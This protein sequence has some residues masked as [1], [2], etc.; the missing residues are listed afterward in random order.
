MT[1]QIAAL[2][3][4]VCGG[5]AAGD[6][7]CTT[8]GLAPMMQVLSYRRY[9]EMVQYLQPRYDPAMPIINAVALLANVVAAVTA[10]SG[11]WFVVAAVLVASV[12]GVSVAKAVPINRFVLKLDPADEPADWPSRDP[13]ARW[14][15]WNTT[16]TVLMAGALLADGVA[17]LY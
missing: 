6:M 10:P 1:Y 9:V 2:L 12:I 8:V 17:V 15:A 7:F 5:I 4:L 14:K 11:A 16:R 13:R 3:A